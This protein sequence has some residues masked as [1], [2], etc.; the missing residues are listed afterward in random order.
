MRT[1]GSFTVTGLSQLGQNPEDRGG[2]RMDE[3][4]CVDGIDQGHL[5][6]KRSNARPG[7]PRRKCLPV[8]VMRRSDEGSR[9]TP[10]K[11]DKFPL[12]IIPS[13]MFGRPWLRRRIRES[14]KSKLLL[15]NLIQRRNIDT[16]N[17]I[18]TRRFTCL[19]ACTCH[20]LGMFGGS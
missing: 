15:L 14:Q 3:T 6:V 13:Y 9:A 5:M 1:P 20:G 17:Q 19:L 18:I 12:T 7:A 16:K 2:E 10:T 4:E 8:A 11:A